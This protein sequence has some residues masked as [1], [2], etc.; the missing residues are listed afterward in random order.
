MVIANSSAI[1]ITGFRCC[2]ARRHQF[3]PEYFAAANQF[4]APPVGEALH[5]QETSSDADYCP[6]AEYR[7]VLPGVFDFHAD[8]SSDVFQ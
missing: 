8:S 4:A 7:Q 3:E 5:E 2:V 6:V 1:E